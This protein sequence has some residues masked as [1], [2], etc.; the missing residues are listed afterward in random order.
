MG[1]SLG[2][3]I[4]LYAL[5][6]HTE[7]FT[8]YVAASPAIGWGREV[9]YQYEKTFFEKK[10]T[11]SARVYMTIGEVER[12]V[13]GFER[14]S[15]FVMDRNYTTVSVKSKILENTGHSGTK[16]ETFG[17]GLQYVFEKPKL[18]L[19][20]TV[21]NKYVGTY[22]TPNGNKVELKN[23]NNQLALYFTPTFKYTLF[24]AA[25]TDF[26]SNNEFFNMH[27]KTSNGI[28][29]G[30]QLDRYGNSQFIKKAN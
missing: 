23:E 4:T 21:L 12:S 1:C 18:K 6:T 9:I 10:P 2:G 29:E 16:S 11:Q 25:E 30:F 3:L 13:P 26:Y 17:R 27:F 28:V 7:L 19:D 14:F 5:F 15:K 8:G 24:A 22:E 20:A